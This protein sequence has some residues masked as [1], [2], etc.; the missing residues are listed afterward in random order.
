MFMGYYKNEKATADVLKDG[1]FHT[2]D[3]GYINADGQLVYLDRV[4]EMQELK[5]G[6]KFSPQFIEM[7][8]RFSPYVQDV[9]VIGDKEHGYVIAIVSINFDNVGR[10]VEAQHINYTTLINLSQKEE[11]IE[12]IKG[13]IEKVN[14]F[15]PEKVRIRRFVVLHKEFDADESELTRTRKLKRA[16][17]R[18][19]YSELIEG[20]YSD[21]N[22]VSINAVVTYRDGKTGVVKA[23]VKITHAN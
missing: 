8:L 3:A 21:L 14:K 6:E 22:E 9:M 15:V 4:S 1:W 16:S 10:W 5:G 13:E 18:Q 23:L 2:G 17:I 12:L 7:R 20:V 19:R 11:V